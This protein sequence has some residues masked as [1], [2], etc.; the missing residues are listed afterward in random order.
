MSSRRS[1]T[2]RRAAFA[3]AAF[4]LASALLEG[5][6]RLVEALG[7]PLIPS[8]PLPAPRSESCVPDCLPGLAAYP[9]VPEG[10]GIRM[11]YAP[12]REWWIAVP[13]DA[14]LQ[15][16]RL[17]LRGPEVPEPKA[18]GELRIL[19]LGDSTIWGHGVADDDVF[20]SVAAARMRED[21][22]REVRPIIGAQPGHDVRMSWNT[23]ERLGARLE[24][25]IVLIANQWSDLFHEDSA[26]YAKAPG[27]QAPLALYRLLH[28]ALGPLLEPR[29]IGWID[30]ERG[31]GVPAPGHVPRTTL[32]HYMAYIEHMGRYSRELGATPVYL[33][34]PAPVDLDPAGAPGF[35]RSYRE[36][37]R[38]VAE[39]L[40]APLIDAVAGFREAGATNAHFYDPVHPSVAGHALL[41][42]IVAEGLEPQAH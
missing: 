2:L 37:M 5:A 40:D 3:L 24:P 20:S 33:L 39:R 22:G 9:E 15:S 26:A 30:P 4:L 14:S 8:T 28:R 29:V 31:V 42:A 17:G 19:T 1:P 34:L 11:V 41:G 36:A 32:P 18:P 25:D 6:A 16:N 27:Q 23:L 12:E 7:P 38:L 21:L 13:D 35:I 10:P